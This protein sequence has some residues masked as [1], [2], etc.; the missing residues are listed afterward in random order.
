MSA[1]TN[2]N[3]SNNGKNGVK[4][5]IGMGM[6]GFLSTKTQGPKKDQKDMHCCGCGGTGH[7]WR[8]CLTPRQGKNLSFKLA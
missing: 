6:A 1:I 4:T 2:K 8:E 3:K 7:G 5:I